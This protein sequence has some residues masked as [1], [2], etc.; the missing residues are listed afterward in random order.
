MA[1][2]RAIMSFKNPWLVFAGGLSFVA[3]MLHV[4]VIIGGSDWY[5]FFGAGEK[6]AKMAAQGSLYPAVVT[7]GIAGALFI[8]GLYAL[9]GAGHVRPLPFL[10]LGLIFITAIYTLRGVLPFSAM[11]VLPEL[12][13]P[14][15]IWSSLVCCVYALA[16][17]V[18]TYIFV[19]QHAGTQECA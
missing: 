10:K 14:F 13:T 1:L 15:T 2:Q 18:G 9:S 11:L 12:I 6:M 16:Y 3:S 17:G 4:A 7:S 8:W 5:L 19:R